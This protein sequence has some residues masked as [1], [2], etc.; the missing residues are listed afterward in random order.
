MIRRFARRY[1]PGDRASSVYRYV[2]FDLPPGVP[3]LAV[4]LSCGGDGAV[5]DLG[6]FDER[7]FRGYS[8][9]ARDRFV[10]TPTAAT[11]GYLPGPLEAGEWRVLLGLHRVP[12]GGVDLTVE[13][14]L[15][16]VTVPP[17]PPAPEPGP[18][19]SRRRLPAP[20]GRRWL[21]CDLHAHTL[22]SDGTL[23]IAE[24]ADTAR[25]RGLDVLAVTD[26]NTVSHHPWLEGVGR[27]YGVTLLPGQE[28]TTDRG[29]ANCFGDV[30][31]VDFRRPADEWLAHA[32]RRGG[33]LS[34]NHP[35]DGDRAWRLPV[36]RRPPLVEA[37]H[38]SWDRRSPEPLEW[39]ASW[40]GV[41]IGGSDFHGS[42]GDDLGAP[43]TWVETESGDPS[44][45]LTGLSAGRVAVS[46]APD[47]PV[48][49]RDGDELV[50]VDASG[51]TVVDPEGR[52]EPVR[53]ARDR[54]PAKPGV[55]RLVDAA[56]RVVALVA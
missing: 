29:H 53:R 6:L 19:P 47:G 1:T 9:G 39:W 51:L 35:L 43:T 26:H 34:V 16:T 11:P 36:S 46:A 31:W 30:G 50:A 7:G 52:T 37:W 24:L 20:R 18:R 45:V 44:A 5:V 41:G 56:G 13:V 10:V 32:E 38:S 27:R 8:G 55:H 42:P 17:G 21:A 22:H 25:R 54:F 2:P 15:G 4:R 14:E 3:G 40:G 49:L 28:V 48:L 33:L 23:T 12:P